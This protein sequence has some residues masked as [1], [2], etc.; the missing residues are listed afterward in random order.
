MDE[1]AYDVCTPRNARGIAGSTPFFELSCGYVQRGGHLF[2]R[3]GSGDPWYRRQHYPRDRRSVLHTPIDDPA[4][5][6]GRVTSGARAPSVIA[7][8]R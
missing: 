6:F 1:R 5:E 2:P 3:Q 7:A 8:G 4:L